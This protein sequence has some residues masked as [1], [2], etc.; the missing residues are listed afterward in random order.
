M[1]KVLFAAGAIVLAVAAPAVAQS[2]PEKTSVDASTGISPKTQEFVT[3]ATQR[4]MLQ[5]ASSKL[6]LVQADSARSKQFASWMVKDHRA[7][8]EELKAIVAGG[9]AEAIQPRFM[10]EAREKTLD[11]LAKLHG[12]DFTR[13]YD[14][15]QRA[16]LEDAVSLFERYARNGD[17]EALRR[18]AS[19]HLPHLQEHLRTV[20]TMTR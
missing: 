14:E 1:K 9:S 11:G 20:Q 8:S 4:D 16:A 6:A 15:L 5:V 13:R 18:F 19:K 7:M 10:D 17:N 2:L 12:K 3:E